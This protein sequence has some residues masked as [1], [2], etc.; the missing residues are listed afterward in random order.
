[1]NQIKCI[2]II[3]INTMEKKFEIKGGNV[4]IYVDYLFVKK[5]CFYL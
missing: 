1:L 3:E 5:T 2:F 4:D